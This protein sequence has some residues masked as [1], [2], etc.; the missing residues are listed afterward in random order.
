[1]P[2]PLRCRFAWLGVVDYQLAS[3][4][5]RRL[6][7]QVRDESGPNTLLLLEHPHVYTRGRLS[8]PE[9]LLSSEDDLAAVGIPV[10]DTDRGGQ[11]TYH[12]PGQLIGYPVVDLRKWGGPLQYVRT[13]EQAIV[14][15]MADFGISAHT[16][17]GFTGVWTGGGKLAAIG[18]KISRGV[19][20]HGFSINV[21]TDLSFYRHIVPCGIEDRA[22]TSMSELLGRPP[23]SEAVRYSVV[24]QFGKAMGLRMEEMSDE[25]RDATL[26]PA[27]FDTKLGRC[28]TP[29][30]T[31]R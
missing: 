30:R 7:A 22:V 19:A 2:G 14:A 4:L 27:F 6:A 26:G 9:H 11:I 17:P 8:K 5:Q 28:Y 18:I 13:L 1:M 20:F 31:A 10:V 3:D 24:Y 25:A 23:D 21:T 12:G 16:E 29:G 15:V